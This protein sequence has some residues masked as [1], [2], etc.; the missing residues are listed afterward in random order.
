MTYPFG[1]VTPGRSFSSGSY[2]YG[3]N[4]K[5]KDDETYGSNNSYDFGDRIY[6]NR[7]AR[8][9]SIDINTALAPYYSTYLFAG[10]TPIRFIDK[11]GRFQ[12]APDDRKNYPVLDNVLQ[13]LS[14]FVAENPKVL[15]SFI[16]NSGLSEADAKAYI[17]YGKSSPV[18]D[19]GMVNGAGETTFDGQIRIN[20]RDVM[21]LEAAKAEL[22]KLTS[23]NA[24]EKKIGKAK[25]KY[26]RRLATIAVTVLHEGVHKGDIQSNGKVTDNSGSGEQTKQGF[27]SPGKER[28]E[29]FEKDAFGEVLFE[30]FIDENPTFKDVKANPDNVIDKLGKPNTGEKKK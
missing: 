7:L 23:E 21:K 24:S 2:R 13:N 25:E 11:N 30:K 3:F 8:F 19:I 9:V 5:E 14:T 29:D 28:G 18:L 26:A 1:S 12:L 17:E 4:S 22:D 27:T 15:E 6:N 20:K 10:N 16:K